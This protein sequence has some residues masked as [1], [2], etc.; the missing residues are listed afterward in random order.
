MTTPPLYE[1]NDIVC[2][3][4]GE[5]V[6]EIASLSIAAEGPL[7]FVGHNGSGKSTLLKLL[8]FL[9]PPV[10]GTLRFLG[11]YPERLDDARLHTTLLLQDPYLLRRSVFENVAYGLKARGSRDIRNRVIESL[12]MVG[13]SGDFARREWYQL[14]GGEARRVALASRLVL[15]TKVLMLDEPTANVDEENAQLIAEAILDAWKRWDTTPLIATHDLQWLDTVTQRR[16]FM[17]RGK[18]ERIAL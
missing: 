3:Y 4:E 15:R 5:P 10:S 1:L 16:I 6:L 18:I 8:A 13:L 12:E 2:A 11:E 7:A 14:S 9:L 17:R